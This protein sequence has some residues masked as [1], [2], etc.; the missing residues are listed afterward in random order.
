MKRRILTLVTLT[1]LVLTIGSQAAELRGIAA[2]PRISF[3]NA[4]ANGLDDE[5]KADYYAEYI[6]I[7]QEVN[8]TLGSQISV[9]PIEEI[10]DDDWMTP[11]EFREFIIAIETW[12]VVCDESGPNERSTS[13]KTKTDTISVSGK[14]YTISI[15][16][17][18]TTMLVGSRQVFDGIDSITSSTSGDG[19]WTHTGYTSSLLDQRRTYSITVSGT[20]RIASATFANK[21]ASADFYCGTTGVVS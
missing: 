11:E 21:L 2:K 20:F 19:T 12:N 10:S 6:K 13:S 18:F 16:G 4:T 9:N 7:A 3:S 14:T 17:R 8:Q 1:A 15:T 5:T